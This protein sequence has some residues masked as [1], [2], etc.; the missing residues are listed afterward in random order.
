M[1]AASLQD[2]I[3]NIFVRHLHIKPP[4]PDRDLIDSGTIDSLTFVEL[5]AHLEREF[6]I[7]IPLDDLDLDRFR[8]ICHIGEFI[9][10]R[11]FMSEVSVGSYSGI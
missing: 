3:S 1:T 11:L 6:D 9:Q 5:I 8:S 10:T 7:R 2:R 4:S